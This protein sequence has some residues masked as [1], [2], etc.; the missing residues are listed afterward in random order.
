METGC[1]GR[2]QRESAPVTQGLENARVGELVN[3]LCWVTRANYSRRKEVEPEAGRI[4][5]SWTL[6]KQRVLCRMA[7]R[8]ETLA[9]SLPR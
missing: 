8:D 2:V 6:G 3:Q 9:G 4:A 1:G 5:Q 7:G